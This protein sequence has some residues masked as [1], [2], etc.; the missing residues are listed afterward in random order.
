MPVWEQRYRAVRMSLPE[1][2]DDAPARNLYLSNPT[3]TF[4]LFAWDRDSGSTHQLTSRPNGTASGTLTPD[5]Q[6][7]WWFNDTD[8]DEFGVWMRQPFAAPAQD[9]AAEPALPGLLA[10]YPA[11]LTL[12]RDGLVA[13][14]RSDEQGSQLYTARLG[15]IG[16]P[17][18]QEPSLF[19]A[20]EGYAHIGD[21]SRDG[22]LLA[23]TH[24]EHGD[25]RHQAARVL[26]LA[27]DGT[28]TTVADLWDGPGKGVSV[29]GFSPLPGD[30]RLVME[31]ER[32]GRT[33]LLIWNP[34][35]WQQDE[36]A[37]DLPGE[38]GAQWFPDGQALL[39]DHSHAGRSELYRYELTTGQLTR[40][41]IPRGT[42]L[43][44]S[45]RPDGSVEYAWSCA[46]TPKRFISTSGEQLLTAPGP[47]VPG[48]VPVTDAWVSGPGGPV[49][50]LISRPADAQG[51][52]KTGPLPTILLIHGGPAMHDEDAF[53]A[54]VA[55]WVDQGY[56][57]VQVN[58]RGSTGYGSAWRDANEGR[59]GLTELEDIAAV[60][61]WCIDHGISDPARIMITG[62]S[63]GGYLTLLAV[64]V[65][66]DLWAGGVAMVPVADYV[67]AYE[68]E[69]EA[70]KE[71]DDALFGGSPEQVPEL[72][73][74]CSPLTYAEAVQA[75]VFILAGDNDPRCPIRQIENYVQALRELGK[76]IE[77]YRF[78][79]GHGSLVVEETI[80]QQRKSMQ[81]IAKLWGAVAPEQ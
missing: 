65:Q 58:Y 38:L 42:V 4:E 47:A 12:G 6:Q 67:A 33:E 23:I 77:H 45:A 8:G 48:S 29:L 55:A 5:G 70:L 30:A 53:D 72:Y 9:N 81:F 80:T 19:Y 3:G 75:P 79:A 69:M 11:G 2:A 31:H 34:E 63:W 18:L 32:R 7:V 17:A 39:I 44:A 14:G 71:F 50:A 25:S 36:L 35:T 57:V 54:E 46:S 52:A 51:E 66:P 21:L 10:S 56:A 20:H 49:H 60:R 22:T 68:D 24:S 62:G 15:A 73:R 43:A 1:W 27:S 78:D 41:E 59:P 61:Q 40:L 13:V 74:K 16:Q 64:G 37:I 76:P 28:T 26:R